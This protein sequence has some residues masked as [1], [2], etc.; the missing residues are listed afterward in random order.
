[1]DDHL[2]RETDAGWPGLGYRH[3][4]EAEPAGYGPADSGGSPGAPWFARMSAAL[5]ARFS[6]GPAPDKID[7]LLA[8]GCF[9]AFSGPV[10][11]GLATGAGPLPAIAVFGVLA[12]APLIVRRRWPIATLAV[13]VIVYASSTLLGVQFTPL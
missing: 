10:L 3:G 4:M 12:S 5:T 7:V 13:L 1:M 8:A 11:A 2:R 6:H 9:A